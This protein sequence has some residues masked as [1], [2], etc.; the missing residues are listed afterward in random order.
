M[1]ITRKYFVLRFTLNTLKGQEM[2]YRYQIFGVQIEEP[3]GFVH[4]I[5]KVVEYP[6][7]HAEN[8]RATVFQ[9]VVLGRDRLRKA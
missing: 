5:R 2:G 9:G 8:I 1:I 4:E 6:E 3:P 7:A